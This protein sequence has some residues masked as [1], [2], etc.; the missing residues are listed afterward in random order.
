M[1]MREKRFNNLMFTRKKKNNI[2]KINVKRDEKNILI[3]NYYYNL[4]LNLLTQKNNWFFIEIF[5]ILGI[6]TK[7]SVYIPMNIILIPN[8]SETRLV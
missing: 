3:T 2:W 6:H 1:F 4:I 7:K 8:H 5:M